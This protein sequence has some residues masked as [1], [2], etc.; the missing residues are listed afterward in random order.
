MLFWRPDRSGRTKK[1]LMNNVDVCACTHCLTWRRVGSLPRKKRREELFCLQTLQSYF[2]ECCH[3]ATAR[4][5]PTTTTTRIRLKLFR[6]RWGTF[7]PS[8]PH[9]FFSHSP[10][11]HPILNGSIGWWWSWLYCIVKRK[12]LQSGHATSPTTHLRWFYGLPAAAAS[13]FIMVVNFSPRKL[14]I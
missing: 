5:L 6:S 2:D 1:T 13:F 4:W 14:N 7:F 8:G 3:C 12:V 9:P 11:P 10:I